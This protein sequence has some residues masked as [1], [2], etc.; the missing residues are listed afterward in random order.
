VIK[1]IHMLEILGMNVIEFVRWMIQTFSKDSIIFTGYTDCMQNREILSAIEYVCSAS[2]RV[3]SN[4]NGAL[5][6]RIHI[7]PTVPLKFQASFATEHFEVLK[8]GTLK[9]IQNVSTRIVQ[10]AQDPAADLTFNLKL[11]ED[12]RLAKDSLQLP[13]IHKNEFFDHESTSASFNIDQDEDFEDDDPDYD[14]EI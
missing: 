1:G 4:M 12:Q 9:S 10:S 11:T 13:Y 14:L 8:D 2:V 6:A 5:S 3:I 7:R